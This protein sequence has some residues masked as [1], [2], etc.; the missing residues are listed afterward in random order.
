[1]I[2]RFFKPK[3]LAHQTLGEEIAN[4]ITHGI[5][6]LLGIAALVIMIIDSDEHHYDTVTKIV[7]TTI[8]GVALIINYLSSSIYHALPASKSKKFFHLMDHCSIFLLIAGTYTPVLLIIL[9]NALGWTLFFIMW[10]I[11]LIGLLMKFCFWDRFPLVSLILYLAMAWT[12]AIA[13]KPLY[14]N[15]STDGFLWLLMGGFFYTFGVI[16]FVWERLK[17]SHAIWHIFTLLG[18][19]CH[20]FL[21]IFYV[22]AF[23]G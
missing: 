4:T 16:F 13:F 8:F 1:M 3:E 7:G 6:A 20:F 11:A 15:L 22:I 17:Y 2:S 9:N 21:M 19:T 18:S 10:S 5:G 12:G 23:K 14:H